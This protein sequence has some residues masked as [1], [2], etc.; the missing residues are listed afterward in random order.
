MKRLNVTLDYGR[1]DSA[2]ALKSGNGP[3]D[4]VLPFRVMDSDGTVVAEDAV[5]SRSPAS[6]DVS[7]A[8]GDLFVRLTWPSG[9]TLTKK[10]EDFG[11]HGE[12]VFSDQSLSSHEWSAWAVP[13]LNERADLRSAQPKEPLERQK[14][15]PYGATTVTL[16]GYPDGGGTWRPVPMS[17][18]GSLQDEAS[19]QFDMEL[20]DG[21]W[22]LQLGGDKVNSRFISLPGRGQCRVL[23]TP[24]TSSDPRAEPL[25]VVVTG[26]RQEAENLLEFLVRDSLRAADSLAN[27]DNMAVRLLRDSENDPMAALAGAYYILRSDGWREPQNV[28]RIRY[29]HERHRAIADTALIYLTV[30]VRRGLVTEQDE[31]DATALFDGAN[32]QGYPVYSEAMRLFQEVASILRYSKATPDAS[33]FKTVKDLIAAK[34]WAGSFFSFYGESPGR[35]AVP[36]VSGLSS[37]EAN[38]ERTPSSA[39]QYAVPLAEISSRPVGPVA[40]LTLEVLAGSGLL[41]LPSLDGSASA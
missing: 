17:I 10:V 3:S 1:T 26:F 20:P 36:G 24:N 33:L 11:D 12:V 22:L 32:D 30:L 41:S 31:R 34:A 6:L 29:L 25:K 18:R 40:P 2:G 27:H 37:K 8:E 15:F 23:V 16:W 9:K 4:F 28:Q 5:G 14:I 21:S 7:A 35:P 19:L 39:K 38:S 13:R